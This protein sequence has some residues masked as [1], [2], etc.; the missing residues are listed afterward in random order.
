MSEQSINDNELVTKI[1]L[2]SSDHAKQFEPG[3][4][5]HH[6]EFGHTIKHI[7]NALRL[8][9]E[10]PEKEYL[11]NTIT[12]L[13]TRG[14]G[15][16]SFLL[17]IKK[18][19]E[20]NGKDFQ[21]G[22]DLSQIQVLDIID[23][24]LIEEKG[25][26]FL[27]VI[28]LV[29]DLV[30]ERL[31]KQDCYPTNDTKSLHTR[32]EWRELLNKL[33]AGLPSIDGIGNYNG[34]SWQDPEFV[35]DNGLKAV[36]ASQKLL[37]NF[38]T[39]LQKS[40]DI[41]EKKAFLLIF[42]DIDVDSSKGWV[43]LETIRK[44]FTGTKLI[45]LIS[46]DLELYTTVVRQKKWKNFGQEILK[47]E[48]AHSDKKDGLGEFSKLVT[49]LTAQY[50]LKVMQ[51]HYRVHLST[52]LQQKNTKGK[53]NLKV[54]LD[55]KS[56]SD[57]LEKLYEQIIKQYGIRN[58]VQ[59][60]AFSTFLLSQPLR[61]QIQLLLVL[62]SHI[63]GE[64]HKIVDNNKISDIF[65]SNLLEQK[66]D[67]PMAANA[68][69]Y[70]TSVIL[71]FLI[72]DRNLE[73]LYQLQPTT[74]SDSLNASLYSLGILVSNT[75]KN[76]SRFVIFDY[77]I[78]VGYLRNLM[79]LLPYRDAELLTEDLRPSIED[80]C[81][82]SGVFHDNV[83]RDI[84]G[85]IQAYLYGALD[86][87]S[88]VSDITPHFIQLKALKSVARQPLTDR[89]DVVFRASA[90]NKAQRILGYIPA[91]SL[92]FSYKN[93]SRIGYSF[94]LLLSTIGEVLKQY[95]TV[96]V[97]VDEEQ[98]VALLKQILKELSQLRSYPVV[99]FV[100]K[101]IDTTT[102]I[103]IEHSNNLEEEENSEDRS[104]DD[105]VYA[106][107][108][109]ITSGG[110]IITATHLLGRIATRFF[111]A[112]G[113]ITESSTKD[114]PLDELFH[115]Q[116]VAFLNAVLIEDARENLDGASSRLNINNTNTDDLIFT[117]NLRVMIRQ[118]SRGQ[119]SKLDFSSW[120]FSCPILQA[121]LKHDETSQI[122]QLLSEYTGSATAH[123]GARQ[124]AISYL[125]NQVS[126]RSQEKPDI[127]SSPYSFVAGTP[128][129]LDTPHELVQLLIA[130]QI[131]YEWFVEGDRGE[132]RRRNKLIRQYLSSVFLDNSLTSGRIREFRTY[133]TNNNIRW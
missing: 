97:N 17:S 84:T 108:E 73:D 13:G 30:E 11:H 109:W 15:K 90:A 22:I 82:R 36:S 34:D 26:V 31:N 58:A 50:M 122:Y 119:L 103:T 38:N 54:S 126:I 32:K 10:D 23:P 110:S 114:L 133:L 59:V 8:A 41:I 68:P 125:L 20:K 132:A 63:A 27:N 86:F 53:L 65:L 91:F 67:I 60:Q 81:D 21:N 46:G 130:N 44:Y 92:S 104:E 57:D 35:M 96:L 89:L 37:K 55:D 75:I 101:Q 1:I 52:L 131:P 47:Y 115:R 12:I 118:R 74:T 49:T 111:Y 107:L 71:K 95:E 62:E 70:L 51:P 98:K 105:L 2:K 77:M 102:A 3:N 16:T 66:I 61:S 100:K 99:G 24:T 123:Q 72:K 120:M 113:N 43:V 116:V 14:S 127:S 128:S 29:M 85:K 42:D 78:K 33:A 93:E 39:F 76:S 7:Q 6:I 87:E 121:Y 112:M 25:H 88:S 48:G 80:L 106:I 69:K 64:G 9:I 124:F 5:V 45:T 28:S 19:I 4:L 40:L 56:K 79:T 18:W 83:F 94:Y 129:L 117:N